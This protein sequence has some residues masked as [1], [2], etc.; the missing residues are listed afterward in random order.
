MLSSSSEFLPEVEIDFIEG[1]SV[2]K[3]SGVD[4]QQSIRH[5]DEYDIEYFLSPFQLR[6]KIRCITI[7]MSNRAKSEFC[8]IDGI[9]VDLLS[10]RKVNR[11]WR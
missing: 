7:H 9:R 1:T 8:T 10:W 2:M 11:P 5:Y 6:R 4:L 3:H